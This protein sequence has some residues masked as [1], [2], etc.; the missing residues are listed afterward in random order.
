MVARGSLE[1]LLE[2][3]HDYL[4]QNKLREWEKDSEQAREVRNLVYRTDKTYETYKSYIENGEDAGNAMITLIS[5]TNYL[6]D[7][8]VASL[9]EKF[10]AEGGFTENL[11]KKRFERRKKD[12]GY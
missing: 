1:E 12:K 10:I 9:K 5:Q 11:A 8:Q 3:Y 6:L 2:D 7:K 4:R